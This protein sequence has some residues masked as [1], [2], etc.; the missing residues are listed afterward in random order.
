[1]STNPT[2]KPPKPPTPKGLLAQADRME[3]TARGIR[4]L[5][6]GLAKKKVEKKP[7]KK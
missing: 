7:V 5:A 1:M 6:K 4:E 3:N 2:P